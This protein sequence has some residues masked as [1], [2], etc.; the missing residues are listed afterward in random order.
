MDGDLLG[1]E[2]RVI[3]LKIFELSEEI[4]T[5]VAVNNADSRVSLFT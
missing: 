3:G 1:L 4:L 5:C 2:G